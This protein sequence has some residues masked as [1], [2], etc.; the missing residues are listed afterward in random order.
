MKCEITEYGYDIWTD[1]LHYGEDYHQDAICQS[2]EKK[3][4]QNIGKLLIFFCPQVKEER[5]KKN[6][7]KLV[8]N[9]S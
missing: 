4:V 5:E 2:L 3:N 1:M 7:V 8:I 9:K 6:E